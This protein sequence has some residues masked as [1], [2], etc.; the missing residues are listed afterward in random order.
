MAEETLSQENY[1]RLQE[2]DKL[3][4]RVREEA[5]RKLAERLSLDPFLIDSIDESMRSDQD[6]WISVTANFE[7][8]VR[9]F[10]DNEIVFAGNQ[11]V[12]DHWICAIE[13]A[14]ERVIDGVG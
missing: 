7:A 5:S 10:L 1:N 13:K 14:V 12:S 3:P 6:W 11:R 8:E 9:N 4:Y 2:W